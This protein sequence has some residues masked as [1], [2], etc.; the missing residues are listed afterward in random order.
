MDACRSSF[1][2]NLGLE[3]RGRPC[4]LRRPS[5][6]GMLARLG[7]RGP[8]AEA[9]R[10]GRTSPPGCVAVPPALIMLLFFRRVR[11][12]C[13]LELL[14]RLLGPCLKA[15]QHP[16]VHRQRGLAAA[17]YVRESVLLPCHT[18]PQLQPVEEETGAR[19]PPLDLGERLVEPS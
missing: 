2:S 8:A 15:N 3:N 16:P 6:L 13:L 5:R 19:V 17:H 11:T 7:S 12:S 1:P 14:G 9:P 4:L 10:P 18:G